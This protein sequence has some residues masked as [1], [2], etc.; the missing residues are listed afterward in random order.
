MCAEQIQAGD[1]AFDLLGPS[2]SCAGDQL[3][4]SAAALPWRRVPKGFMVWTVDVASRLPELAQ[5]GVRRIIS[6]QP[7]AMEAAR[8]RL[9][10]ASCRS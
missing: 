2:D 8:K 4:G 7:L 10:R 6:N 9:L 3:F 1:D 5:A